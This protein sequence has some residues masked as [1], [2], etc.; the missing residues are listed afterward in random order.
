MSGEGAVS[1][2]ALSDAQMV[3]LFKQTSVFDVKSALGSNA[4]LAQRGVPD[5]AASDGEDSGG[6]GERN[7]VRDLWSDDEEQ[8]RAAAPRQVC[9]SLL[10]D[11]SSLAG[12]AVRTAV[13]ADVAVPHPVE[14]RAPGLCCDSGC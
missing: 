11:S 5:D 4:V 6:R 10:T 9:A 2:G 7:D 3:E 14:R 8:A 12:L 1:S 13:L